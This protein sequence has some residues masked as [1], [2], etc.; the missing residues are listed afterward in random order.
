M[1]R[2][3]FHLFAVAI[4]LASCTGRN[5]LK[6]KET[7]FDGQIDRFQNLVFTF[8]KDLVP[9]S[10]LNRWDTLPYLTFEP[11]VKGKF[12]WTGKRELT[13]SPAGPFAFSTDYKAT[14][15]NY[16]IHHSAK[17]YSIDKEPVKFHTPYLA[18]DNIQA[19]WALAGGEGS[20]VE[21]RVQLIFN[22]PVSP[23]IIKDFVD[24]KT[25]GGDL[26]YSVL[27]KEELPTI[28]LSV[29]PPQSSADDAVNATITIH[30]GLKCV[31][32]AYTTPEAIE[33]TF[34]IPSR[35]KLA[36]SD[37]FAEFRE[38][39]GIVNVFT[40]QP[41]IAEGISQFITVEPLIRTEVEIL[42]NG[43]CLKGAFIE[44]E[45]YTIKISGKLKG[46]FGKEMGEDYQQSISFGQLEPY[47]S[48]ADKKGMYLS[49]RGERNLGVNIINIP[50]VKISVFKIFENNIQAY[51]RTGQSYDY[52][53]EDDEYY[54]MYGYPFSEDYGR[55]VM[56]REVDTR[57]LPKSGNI[58]L[59]NLNLEDLNFNE[60]YKG[61]Y[62]VKVESTDKRWLQDVQLVSLSDLG[63]IVKQGKENVFVF[64]NSLKDASPVQ[65]AKVELVS[66]NNQKVMSALTDNKGV[67]VFRDVK[68][69]APGF[70]I[71]MITARLANDFNYILFNNSQ[72]ETSRFDVGGKYLG[73]MDYDVF[74]YGDRELYRPG[75]SVFINTIVR[76][77][78][79]QTVANIP[80][81]VKVLGPNGKEY[82]S[83]REQLNNSGAAETRFV[84]PSAAMTGT[85]LVE[86]YSGNDILLNTRRISVEEFMPDRIKVNVKTDKKEYR[87][88]EPVKV[89]LEALNLFGP[90]ATGRN[91]EVELRLSMKKFSPKRFPDY[92]FNVN[93]KFFAK[94]ELRQGKTDAAGKGS[95]NIILPDFKNFGILDGRIFTTVF[96]ETGRPVNR[97]SQMDVITQNVFFGIKNFDS[98]VSTRRPLNFYFAAVN[99]DGTPVNGAK[100][101]VEIK[102]F[103]YENVVERNSNR[104]NYISQKRETQVYTK[105]ITVNGAN[106]IVSFKPARSGEYEVRILLP[107]AENYVAA[108]FYAYGWSDTDYSSFEIN[109]EGEIT[110]SADKLEYQPGETARLLFK[111]PFD[112]T[113]LVTIEQ[114]DV[115]EYRFL[116]IKD[117][118]A[119]LDLKIK[120]EHLPNL[121]VSATAFKK[122]SDNE[123]PLTVAHGYQPV[124]VD[125]PANRLPLTILAP[126][127][128]R[129]KSR[130]QVTIKTTPNTELTVAAVDEGILQITDF[131]SPDPY[132]WYYTKR[133]LGVN[134]Y[135]IYRQLFPELSMRSSSFAGGSPFDLERRI[136][137]VTNK[138]VKLISLWSG[139]C[140]TNSSGEFTFKFDVPQF[141]GALRVMA[142]AYK[143]NRF[144]G[145]EKQIR[146]SDP[147]TLSAAI[148]R[149]LSPGDKVNMPVT[150]SNTTAK[151]VDVSVELVVKG[152]AKT[153]GST[154]Q[155]VKIQANSEK[156]IEFNIEALQAIGQ[157]DI[158][159][160]AKGLGETFTEL[161]HVP[162]RPPSGLVRF[163]GA[164]SVKAGNS[165]S[166]KINSGMFPAGVQSHLL[167]SKSPIA[168]FTGNLNSLIR[169]PYG[170]M[171]QTVSAAFPQIYLAD[172]MKALSAYPG[173]YREA[174][175][176]MNPRYNVQEAIQK[177]ETFQQYNGGLSTWPSGGEVNWWT[178]AYAAHFL[179]EAGK[180]GY[181]VNQKTLQ[182]LYKYLE[183]RVKEKETATWYYYENNVLKSQVIPR[184]EIMYSLYVLTLAGRQNIPLMN[185]YRS[186]FS[187]LNTE[188]QYLLAASYMQAG[189]RTAYR[190][191]LPANA[192][193]ELPVSSF[194]GCFDSYIRE[195]ALILYTL[196]DTDPDNPQI[197]TMVN[198]LSSGLRKQSWYSTQENAFALLALGR[199]AK[200]AANSAITADVKLN[201]KSI[202]NF[203]GK[204][205]T[206]TTNLNNSDL[207]ITAKGNGTLFYFYEVSGIKSTGLQHDEDNFLEVRKKFY[208]R[209]GR[210]LSGNSFMQ[211]DMVVVE[212]TLCAKESSSVE[213]VAVTDLLPACFEIENSRLN[214][215]RV[216][217]WMK[218]ATIPEYTDIRDDRIS[219]FTTASTGVKKFYYTVRVVGKGEYIMGPV[220][221]DAMY[222]GRY[223]S[224]SGSGYVMVK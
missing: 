177:I 153:T 94:Q 188:S 205:L 222:D 213:N 79:W 21:V 186:K 25:A 5:T 184:Q 24:L 136:N 108:S 193:T 26:I 4:L 199:F 68:K 19:Y 37:M 164:G 214:A 159:V 50:K 62:L 35:D 149:F 126:E 203:D 152:T 162:V 105:D 111:S 173:D 77:T 123:L 95:Q 113:M 45:T 191:L 23:S 53:Y 130:Q 163:T 59:L 98:W 170:C 33:K 66:S 6:V 28:E 201:G 151:P 11:S 175:T 10:L 41:V 12:R 178:S 221:A 56:S 133:A 217:D 93:A 73:N 211:N 17:Q 215:E 115:L 48:F 128:C 180:A 187:E 91:Y 16:L 40:T 165:K 42:D 118:A 209:N 121:Y 114:E 212:I 135:D 192:G 218:N 127:K 210:V 70:T 32:S 141:S 220:S 206:M 176:E 124:K 100:A 57:S 181:E 47:I 34:V 72:V 189:D 120:D 20:H 74:I 122:I 60:S 138:R 110:I 179:Y 196:L 36:I 71:A 29:Q 166:V 202:G 139:L 168:E 106:G 131:K 46:V 132:A 208:D 167:I 185:Y 15:G 224:Y 134:A 69:T 147:L 101:R 150:I 9:D 54:D 88:G 3:F 107:G 64:V 52:Y 182:N 78:R 82:K 117:K 85:Y 119:S 158:S 44:N 76:T 161:T 109:K 154:Y 125:K 103:H 116:E 7:N 67:A 90:P 171:E 14:P 112:G 1:N 142:V 223:H 51:M 63:M 43:F 169:Y 13:F 83:F 2:K 89:D 87:Q 160:I 155:Q 96:D 65:G 194:G 18:L 200:L 97:L 144:G 172:L 22:S 81:K 75:D 157:A 80:L 137:P 38:G 207:N 84:L 102:Y 216:A 129:S 148:P 55:A 145:A 30:K 58:R 31:G 104:Y 27:S 174:K 61:F 39:K 99:K 156:L 183:Q 190:Q 49:A 204:D 86:A 143:D 140:R 195:R 8:N 197:G 92:D 146:V 219:F 198:L